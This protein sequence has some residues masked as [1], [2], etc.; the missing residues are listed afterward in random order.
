MSCTRFDIYDSIYDWYHENSPIRPNSKVEDWYL[1]LRIRHE[2]YSYNLHVI[3]EDKL[4]IL[5]LNED[6]EQR[7]EKEELDLYLK[8]IETLIKNTLSQFQE[9]SAQNS[10]PLVEYPE[11]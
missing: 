11:F 3:Y 6:D 9:N 10:L 5:N 8:K 4:F 2:D 1:N 7:M